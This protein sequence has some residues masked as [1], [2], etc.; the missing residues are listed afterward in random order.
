MIRFTWLRFRAQAAVVFGALAALA[1]VLAVTGWH[2]AHRYDTT[3]AACQPRGGCSAAMNAFA[4]SGSSLQAFVKLLLLAAPVLIGMFWGAP[5]LAR[6]FETGTFRLAWTQDVTPTRWLAVKLGVVGLASVAAAGLLSLMVTWWS[7]PIDRAFMDQW[8]VF[9]QRDI[10]P[11]GYAAFAFALGVTA[12]ML[13]RRTVP[14]M[15]ITLAV[16]AAV[17]V[18]MPLWIRP[19]LITP[20]HTTSPLNIAALQETGYTGNSRLQVVEP[21]NIPGAWV[22]SSP[23]VTPAG[24]LA[25]SEPATRACTTGSGQ[26][27]DAYIATLHLRQVVTYQ[28]A[29]RYWAFQWY[30]TAIFLGL[31]VILAGVCFWQIRRRRSEELHLPH[32]HANRKTPALQRSG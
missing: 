17:Q 28:P 8:G 2:L 27:C 9:S 30:E 19:H 15:A 29:S 26:A 7:S 22:Y 25:S 12:G 23:I 10:T 20:V 18:V 31:A 3:A 5:L 16:F 32:L 6:E 4:N 24:Q 13:I 21:A 14:A 1:V 11:I